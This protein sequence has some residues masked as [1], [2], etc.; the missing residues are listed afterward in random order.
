MLATPLEWQADVI[1]AAITLKLCVH[2]E[3]GAIVAALTTSIPEAPNSGR[4]WDYRY[5]LAARRLLH[6]A[7]AEPARRRRHPRR[8]SRLSAQHHRCDAE[9]AHPAALRRRHGADPAGSG[10]RQ[11]LPGYRGMGP[12]R[13]GNQAH[14]HH[15]HD[16][17]GQIV[18]STVQA[19][20][21]TRLFR[22]PASTISARSKASASAPTTCYAKPDA[23]FGSSAPSAA[24]HTYSAADV[25]GR[26]RPPRQRRAALGSAA[27]AHA[28]GATRADE[29]RAAIE[30]RAWNADLGRFAATLRRRARWTPACC[31]WSTRASSP[32]TIRASSP[33]SNAIEHDL[34]RGDLRAALRRRRRFRQARDR[35]QL[36][37]LLADRS[38][39]PGRPPRRGA[40]AVR[41]DAGAAHA[42][43]PALGRL[44]SR[45]RRAVGQLSANLFAGRPDQLRRAAQQSVE[46]ACDE[47]PHRRLQ[48][49][50]AAG[51]GR[52]REPRR[53]RHG[54]LGGAAR[55]SAASGSAGAGN[56]RRRIHRPALDAARQR[57]HRRD[58]SIS[59][60]R[61]STNTTT[62]T[63][64]ARSGRSSTIASISRSTNA[65]SAKATSASTRASPKRCCR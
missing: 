18:L 62:A 33:R 31:R 25:L 37:H 24:V 55:I 63:P 44:R 23:G 16:V 17:Y 51:A 38:A 22:P 47:P 52:R 29:I 20:Y 1:R 35:L 64:T 27:I 7:G 3:T 53:A 4:N 8:L 5:L 13:V 15:Q 50:V 61:T 40:R 56:R 9:R 41:G 14:E 6:G 36:L 39:A 46:H 42:R 48:S 32:P 12:I 28:I 30:K 45:H 65:R 54:D 57:R 60:S 10:D 59:K 19:F 34:R 43:R 49:R 2:E 26:V 58:A 11:S 21:D